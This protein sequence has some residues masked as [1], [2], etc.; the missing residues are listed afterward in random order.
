MDQHRPDEAE[1]APT[2]PERPK[3]I[4]S[5]SEI[6]V[7]VVAVLL[8]IGLATPRMKNTYVAAAL[9]G[10]CAADPSLPVCHPRRIPLVR[11]LG[12]FPLLRH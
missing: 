6:A 10:Q 9:S 12:F 7:L 8:A 2:A 3:P 11:H 5:K 1:P 4:L